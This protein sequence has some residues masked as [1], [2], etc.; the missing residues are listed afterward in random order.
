MGPV[1]VLLRSADETPAG[2]AAAV[3]KVETVREADI[4]AGEMKRITQAGVNG[5]APRPA[6]VGAVPDPATAS[7]P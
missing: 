1:L 3:G 7:A 5:A 6:G 2:A 4:G